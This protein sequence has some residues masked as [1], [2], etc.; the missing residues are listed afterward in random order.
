M[1]KND[2]QKVEASKKFN[3][4]VEKLYRAW[5]DP[6]QLK[7]WWK[8]MG[9]QLQEV[10]NDLKTGGNVKYS[11]TNNSFQI[12]GVYEDV[13]ENE[14]LLY[15]WNWLFPDNSV[16]NAAYKLD[17]HFS[18]LGETSEIH[19]LQENLQRDE[20]VHPNKEGWE[21]GLAD[22]SHFFNGESSEDKGENLE[23]KVEEAGYRERPE[24]QKVGGG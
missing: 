20:N 18:G 15:S 3:V 10:E 12:E 8:P 6:E 2:N 11:F 19:I 7:Q 9:N 24:Q 16:K 5:N 21:K 23:N 14:H 22:L 1:E 17:V 13:R 4:S